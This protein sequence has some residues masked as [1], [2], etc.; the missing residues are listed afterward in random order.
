MRLIL[1]FRCNLLSYTIEFI[2]I[3]LFLNLF[4]CF[5]VHIIHLKN[6]MH[7]LLKIILNKDNVNVSG[8]I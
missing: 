2:M 5:L 4:L 3:F 7:N 1:I 6:S 8:E